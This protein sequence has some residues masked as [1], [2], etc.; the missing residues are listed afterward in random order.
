[1]IIMHRV[2]ECRKNE[3][4]IIDLSGEPSTGGEIVED[5]EDDVDGG[6]EHPDDEEEL[7]DEAVARDAAP[8]GSVFNE[9]GERRIVRPRRVPLSHEPSH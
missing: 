3:E 5:E 4:K 6:S 8:L 2:Q 9:S 7:V 1:M